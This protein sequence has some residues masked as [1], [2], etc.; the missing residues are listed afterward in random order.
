MRQRVVGLRAFADYLVDCG[1]LDRNP[2]TR[3]RI[4]RTPEGEVIAVR[5]GLIPSAFRVPRLPTDE[6]WSR[7]L[8][9]LRSRPVRD[10][11]MF[12]LAYDGALRRNELVTLRLDDFDFPAQQVTIRAEHAKSGYQRTIVYGANL[13]SASPLS[14][15]TPQALPR[16]AL[17]V[18]FRKPKKSIETTR[19]LHVGSVGRSA[20]A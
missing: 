13:R 11:L 5:R 14:A 7:L 10:R 20:G 6:Q 3:G 4:R 2:V 18:P 12:T 19:R 8:N 17:F 1:R 16:D 15:R 9:S